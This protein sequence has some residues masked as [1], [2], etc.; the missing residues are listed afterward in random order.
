MKKGLLLVVS[1]IMACTSVFAQ[2]NSD[3]N[4]N[5]LVWDGTYSAYTNQMALT[6]DGG[7]WLAVDH[8]S[9]GMGVHISV[10]LVDSMGYLKFEKPI[11]LNDYQASTSTVTGQVLFV[12]RDDNAI[13]VATD[14]RHAPA[15]KKLNSYSVYK[16]SP[17]GEFLWGKDGISLEGDK[18]HK[19]VVCMKICQL[20]DG[21]YVFAWTH[22][23]KSK[24]TLEMQRISEEGEML[25]D[26]DKMRLEDPNTSYT[27]PYLVNGGN[28]QV[29]LIYA[30]GSNMDVVARKIDFDGEPVW[31]EETKIYNGGWGN[32]PPWTFIEVHPTNDGGFF[33]SWYDDRY[34]T[35]VESPYMAYVKGNGE[36]GFYEPNGVKLWYEDRLRAMNVSSA[37][38][39]ATD[40]FYAIW[41]QESAGQ[42]WNG[43]RAQKISK[44]GE[45]LWGEYGIELKPLQQGASYAYSS[46]RPGINDEIGFFYMHSFDLAG[47]NV[48]SFI[49]LV[50]ANDTTIRREMEFTK[51]EN[52]HVRSS[53]ETTEMYDGRYWIAK[54]KES[55]T[56]SSGDQ[57]V[58]Q[59]INNDFTLGNTAVEGIQINGNR[60]EA[61]ATIVENEAMF[62]T[63]FD[64]ATQ[65]TLSIYNMNGALVATP[66][67]GVLNAGTQYI[68]WITNVPAGI[69]VATLSTAQGIETVKIMVK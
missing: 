21:S 54:W 15:G 29:I 28:N 51:A 4:V 36:L 6:S 2:W 40:A 69:Y 5:L 42:S 20:D 9:D 17:E 13:V 25:W 1:A 59:R 8:P 34:M 62:T 27:Y 3:P 43:V 16:I 63:N 49:T 55:N 53:L 33:M 14:F 66:F 35:D 22:T 31:S 61:L 26:A 65:A 64:V 37:Y 24:M 58:L 11:Q 44:E 57:L 46:V 39:P 67:D 10:Q 60:F 50:N 7:V 38:D 18:S 52:S 48:E 23:E 45:L 19:Y 32:V 12:D 56:N 30:K 41:N 47:T 68:S